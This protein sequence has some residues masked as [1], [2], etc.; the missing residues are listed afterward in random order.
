M[1]LGGINVSFRRAAAMSNFDPSGSFVRK[2]YLYREDLSRKGAKRYRVSKG[3]SLRLCAR[4]ILRPSM[5]HDQ[6]KLS[7]YQVNRYA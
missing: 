4:N 6:L 2:K 3:L 1:R 7:F 5:R